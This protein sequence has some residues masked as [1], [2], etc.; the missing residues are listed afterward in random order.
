MRTKLKNRKYLFLLLLIIIFAFVLRIWG[1]NYGLPDIYHTDE[2]RLVNHA[3]AFGLGDLNPHYFNYPSFSMYLLF[4]QYGAYF[5]FGRLLGIFSSVVDFQKLFFS[6]PTSFYLIGRITMT[7]LGTATVLLLYALGK[8][9][10]GPEAGLGAAF[11]LGIN[12][13]HAE[14]SHYI[15]TDILLSFFIVASYLFILSIFKKGMPGAYVWAGIL[16]G[17][18]AASKYNAATL[19][20]PILLAHWWSPVKTEDWVRRLFHRYLWLAAVCMLVAFFLAS[21]FCFLDFSKFWSD[22]R[23][24]AQHMKVGVY[25]TGGGYHWMSYLRLFFVDT[26]Y[27]DGRRWTTL[28]IIYG[29]GIIWALTQ[30]GRKEWLLLSYPVLYF[31]MIGSWGVCNARYLIPVF[32]FL[33]VLGGGMVSF[34][35]AK[36]K[37]RPGGKIIVPGFVVLLSI[38]PVW[39]IGLNDIMLSRI[40]TRT[41][42]RQWIEQ[43]IPEGAKI[44]LEWDNNAT[45]QLQET[46][47][48]IQQKIEAYQKGKLITIHHPSSQMIR[49]HQ[50]RL[51]ANRGKKYDIVRIG[52]VEGLNLI[53]RLYDLEK[54]R[55]LEVDYVIVS[56]GNY[57]AFMESKGRRKYPQHAVFY[58]ELFDDF[59]PIKVF[60]PSNQAGPTIKIYKLN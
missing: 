52:D 44:A 22:F 39:N 6:D 28:G 16:A 42:S 31:L 3:L 33:A 2:E 11:F 27:S 45:V 32:P 37:L 15:T 50:T 46:D 59:I 49:V 48:L 1:V 26:I 24:I 10:Y 25:S 4:F 43:H 55:Q 19:A 34:F 30:K 40:D 9:C 29:A 56:S 53:P 7:V 38:L 57:Y 8:K 20:V 47:L 51:E 18:G 54:L 36:L 58:D 5:A 23:G 14:S 60:Q 35:W 12:F 17:L 21:P 13:L 41:E